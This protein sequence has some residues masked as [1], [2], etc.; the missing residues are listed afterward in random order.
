M[1]SEKV[2]EIK[3]ALEYCI[4]TTDCTDCPYLKIGNCLDVLD[5]DILTLINELESE[6]ESCHEVLADLKAIIKQQNDRIAELEKE[7]SKFVEN[8]EKL[9]KAEHDSDRYK[10]RIVELEEYIKGNAEEAKAFVENWHKDLMKELKHFAERVKMEFYYEF[11][12]LIPSI[13]SDKIDKIL[14]EILGE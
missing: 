12:E 11:D 8:F 2:K 13:M 1:E 10:K 6:N 4:S 14:K 7:S 9:K 5:A 3:K